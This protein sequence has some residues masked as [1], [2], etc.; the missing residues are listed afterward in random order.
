MKKQLPGLQKVNKN[1]IEYIEEEQC[2][3]YYTPGAADDHESWARHLTPEMFW[4]H[5][6]ELLNPSLNDDQVDEIIDKVVAAT[7]ND[8]D[9][10][11]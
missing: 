9:G 2:Y 3:Y 10:G 1:H 5:K 4:K 8:A 11:Q 7:K 6:D